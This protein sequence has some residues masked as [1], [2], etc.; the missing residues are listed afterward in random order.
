M[1][2]SAHAIAVSLIGIAFSFSVCHQL[3]TAIDITVDYR[4]DSNDFF[5][6]ATTDGQQAR[7][8]LEAAAARFSSIITTSLLPAN[9]N[10]DFTD[11]RIGF[12]HP[13]DG[14]GWQVSGAN[15]Q[16]S[17]SLAGDP[18][19]AAD[20]YRGPWSL[21]ADE[22]VLY[23]AGRSLSSSGVGGT[24]TGLNFTSV[25]NDDSSVLNRGFRTGSSFGDLPVWGGAITFD[26]D[27]GVN[28]HFD[29]T[30]ASSSGTTDFYSIALHEIGHV[31][32][33][34]T[35]W[36]DWEAQMSGSTFVGPNTLA[37]YNADNGTS[38]TSLNVEGGGNNHWDDGAYDSKIFSGGNPITVG[39][40]GL[41]NLQDLLMEPIANFSFP[42]RRR[43]EL[44][45]VDVAAL[46]DIGWSV[47][48]QAF[49][50]ADFDTDGDVDG[51]DLSTWESSYASNAGGDAN[52]DGVTDG[53]DFLIWQQNFTGSSPTG[54][55]SS[56]PEP[57]T[58]ALAT[59]GLCAFGW[60]RRR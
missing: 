56:V 12:T 30:V 46:E 1:I 3:A 52:G 27:G 16:A 43:F 10:D 50:P 22:W 2:R 6:P 8:A 24:G 47:I 5:D 20:E 45:N 35:S 49:D 39:T 7:A 44:T 51:D 26:N 18:N 21:A 19:N 60:R 53:E 37:A 33:L 55:L 57:G 25:F 29:H 13:G 54:P 41:G 11:A 38:L 14:G 32:G 34:S 40:V 28:W 31:L 4:Y 42:N 59:F 58:I 17:D 36:N 9:F 48:S 23:A 15:G